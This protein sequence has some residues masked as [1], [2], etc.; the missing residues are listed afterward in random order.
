MTNSF[1][2][3]QGVCTTKISFNDEDMLLGSKLHKQL[4]FIK[5]YVNETMVNCILVDDGLNI[6]ILSLKIINELGIHIYV[7]IYKIMLF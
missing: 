3:S 5:R 1:N 4:F 6:N 2:L 7:Y